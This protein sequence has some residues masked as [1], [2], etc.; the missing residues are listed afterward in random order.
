MSRPIHQLVNGANARDAIT[1]TALLWQKWLKEAGHASE[2]FAWTIDDN[3][4]DQVR[5]W[6]SYPAGDAKLLYHHSLGH[7]EVDSLLAHYAKKLVPVY[8]NVTPAKWFAN[9]HPEL[10]RLCALGKAQLAQMGTVLDFG[11]GVSEFNCAEMRAAGF[12]QTHV[13]PLT[14]E[15]EKYEHLTPIPPKLPEGGPILLFVGRMV[16]N[17]CQE[18]LVRLLYACRQFEPKTQLV[19]VGSPWLPS[20]VEW[21]NYVAEQL[22][23]ADGVHMLGSVSFEELAGAY[24]AADVFVS[25]SEHEGFGMP[26]IEAMFFGLPIVAY[27]AAAVPDTLG[28]AGMTFGEKDFAAVAQLVQ[29]FMV[30]PSLQNFMKRQQHN[31]ISEFL[32]EKVQRK[33]SQIERC[34]LRSKTR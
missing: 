15:A 5:P 19:L 1:Q 11:I 6:H 24:Q 4:A 16:P 33:F 9:S 12:K 23:V 13:V 21:V 22:G 26:L 18:D 17:K 31:R 32:I 2:I 3:V 14:F 25:M 34:H 27:R 7:P 8:H 28:G 29:K 10:A 30:D 20:Y